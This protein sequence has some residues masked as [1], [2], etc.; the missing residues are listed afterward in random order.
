MEV[1]EAVNACSCPFRA[2]G[3][4]VVPR[5]L[6]FLSLYVHMRCYTQAKGSSAIRKIFCVVLIFFCFY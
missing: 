5:G 3:Q 2:S 1:S 6:P 4:D